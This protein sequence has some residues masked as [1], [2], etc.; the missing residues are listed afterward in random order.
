MNTRWRTGVKTQVFMVVGACF[1]GSRF[2]EGERIRFERLKV[3]WA[4]VRF[5]VMRGLGNVLGAYQ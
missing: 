1:V 3:L 4:V 2:G 5:A